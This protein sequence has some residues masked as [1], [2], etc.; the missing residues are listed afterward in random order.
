[1]IVGALVALM[2]LVVGPAASSKQ[3][4]P[5]PSGERWTV[6]NPGDATFG[7]DEDIYFTHGFGAEDLAGLNSNHFSVHVFING[8]EVAPDFVGCGVDEPKQATC[9]KVFIWAFPAGSLAP[10][11]YQ[12]GVRWIAPC[13]TWIGLELSGLGVQT[14]VES[15]L[16]DNALMTNLFGE[17]DLTIAIP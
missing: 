16:D 6:L 2:G 15:C 10:A 17:H 13:A 14:V 5:E 9:D 8:E 7:T 4:I 11:T 12:V 3:S 1:M